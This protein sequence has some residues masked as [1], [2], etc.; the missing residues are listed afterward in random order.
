MGNIG[1][2]RGYSIIGQWDPAD[3]V[4]VVLNYETEKE[5]N[6]YMTV[7]IHLVISKF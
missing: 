1:E 3:P 6:C 5:R 7:A 2:K 4:F